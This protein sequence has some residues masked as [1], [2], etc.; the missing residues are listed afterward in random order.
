MNPYRLQLEIEGKDLVSLLAPELEKETKGDRSRISLKKDGK[1]TQINIEAKDPAA[2]QASINSV[3]KL[4]RV[5][6]EMKEVINEH[7]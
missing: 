2:L 5:H 3:L 1:A 7:S 6:D 4:V